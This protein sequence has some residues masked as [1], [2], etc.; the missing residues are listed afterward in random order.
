MRRPV[1]SVLVAVVGLTALVFAGLSAVAGPA[2]AAPKLCSV[3]VS[4]NQGDVPAAL[5]E[6]SGLAASRAETNTVW[7][8]NDSKGA[9]LH[10]VNPTTGA[11][12]ATYTIPGATVTDWEDLAI[13][14]GAGQYGTLFIG[15]IGG[16]NAARSQ[17]R[18]YRVNEPDVVTGQNADLPAAT[19]TLN[20]P[21]G[22]Y[23]AQSLFVDPVTG[24]AYVITAEP[25]GQARVYKTKGALT[26]GAVK[27]LKFVTTLSL[28]IGQF[29]TGASI[30]VSGKL[31]AIRT[32]GF[33]LQGQPN[34]TD[35]VFIWRRKKTEKVGAAFRRPPCQ[36]T[37]QLNE[38]WGQAIAL[39]PDGAGFFTGSELA[40]AKFRLHTRAL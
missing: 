26:D 31:I 38:A 22:A 11:I 9:K 18:L 15:D 8:L 4:Q 6:L 13:V 5:N 7:A 23:D 29:A 1:A 14:G 2:A 27:Q 30:N 36:P 28:G 12:R 33:N 40:G 21:D 24:E 34:N 20:Y 19:I 16:N 3:L 37:V 10:A 39:L 32:Q 17:I 35:Q 25:T